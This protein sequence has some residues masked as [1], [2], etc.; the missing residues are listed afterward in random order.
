ML[1]PIIWVINPV[2]NSDI[3]WRAEVGT[4]LYSFWKKVRVR[5]G[6][7]PVDCHRSVWT[8]AIH[9]DTDALIDPRLV[10]RARVSMSLIIN[11]K[12]MDTESVSEPTD[13][14]LYAFHRLFER[15]LGTMFHDDALQ[16]V[17][18]FT[19]TR[20]THA[21]FVDQFDGDVSFRHAQIL[22]GE[23]RDVST[24]GDGEIRTHGGVTLARLATE[25]H[26][27]LGHVSNLF[28]RRRGIRTPDFLLVRET[29]YH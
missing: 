10:I 15:L 22:S 12:F 13:S 24:C 18:E 17:V 28:R 19:F 6:S 16:L 3:P 23:Q 11:C 27:P 14:H 8:S 29:L 20:F 2:K 9:S 7:C 5:A 21:L 25:N 4:I 26:K 1:T